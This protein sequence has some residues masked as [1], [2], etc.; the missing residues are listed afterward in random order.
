MKRQTFVPRPDWQARLEAVGMLWHG[1]TPEHPVPYWAEEAGY[2]FSQA[3]IAALE[4]SAQRLVGCV[5]TATD[6]AI[7]EGRLAALGIP[8][9]M[10]AAVRESWDRDDPSVYL[11]LDLA[12][13]TGAEPQ[14]LEVNGQTPTSLLEAAVCQWQ[15]LEDRQQRGEIAASA[16]QWNTI[17]E[18][19]GEQWAHLR[20]ARGLR[21]VMFSAAFNDED[22]A[23][24]TYLRE[25]ANAAGLRTAFLDVDDLGLSR[26][27]EYLLDLWPRPIEHLMWL[28]PFEFAWDASAGESLASTRTRFIEPLWKAVSSSKGLLAVMHELFPDD[29]SILPASLTSGTLRGPAVQKP[30]FSREGQNVVLPGA[31]MT[32]GDYAGYSLIEQAYTELPIYTADDGPRYPVLG[33]WAAGDEVCGLGIREGRG[34][35]TDN[36]AS[37]VPHWV[38]G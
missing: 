18:A 7:T 16:G 17:H 23:T 12:Y 33:V 14:L 20:D 9:F 25:L 1:S 32:A 13:R 24:V 10:E 38:E 4:A 30:L 5:L 15:W 37:F 26:E 29:P 34:R 6:Y 31:A 21:E 19:L 35:V 36:R 11:R 3:E 27:S 2:R 28:W 8:D 22:I